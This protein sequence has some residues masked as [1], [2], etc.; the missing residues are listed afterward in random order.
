VFYHG[1]GIII[2]YSRKRKLGYACAKSK[3][4]REIMTLIS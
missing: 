1:K 4:E 2:G 3:D